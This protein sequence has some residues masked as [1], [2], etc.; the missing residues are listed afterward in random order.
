MDVPATQPIP[1][2]AGLVAAVARYLATRPY[3]EVAGLIAQLDAAV[4][5]ALTPPKDQ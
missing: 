3:S 2:P 1:L 5:A 4:S